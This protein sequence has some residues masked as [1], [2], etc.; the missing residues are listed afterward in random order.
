MWRTTSSEEE[1][2]KANRCE[3]P[4]RSTAQQPEHQPKTTYELGCTQ[5]REPR[6]WNA[7]VL[8]VGEPDL[9]VGATRQSS[10]EHDRGW[11]TYATPDTRTETYCGAMSE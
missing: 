4:H 11:S 8:G 10:S 3:Q 6:R 7:D 5:H 1:Q 9:R 2:D